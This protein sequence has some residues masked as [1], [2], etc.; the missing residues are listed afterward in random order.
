MRVKSLDT[1]IK[2]LKLGESPNLLY[3][4]EIQNGTKKLPLRDKNVLNLIKP[5]ATFLLNS[6][7][8]ILFFDKPKSENDR[9]R[10]HREVW[11]FQTPI[12]FIVE[13]G[14]I[15]IYN[16]LSLKKDKTRLKKI[17]NT[18][19]KEFTLN[20]ILSGQIW[21]RLQKQFEDKRIDQYLL[22]N[23][24]SALSLIT[25]PSNS[26]GLNREDANNLLGRL[27]FIRYL[28]DRNV[29]LGYPEISIQ[30]QK[31]DFLG[32]LLHKERLYGLFKYLTDKFN[33]NLFPVSKN[34]LEITNSL[35][36]GALYRLFKGDD[37]GKNQISLFDVYDFKIIPV[38]LISNIYERFIGKIGQ[39]VNKSFYTPPF[40][41]DYV[42]SNTVERHLESHN[43]CKVLDPS[44][45]SGIFL[46]ETLR[47]VIEKNIANKTES[48]SDEELRLIAKSTVFGVDK[49]PNAINIAIFSI[50]ITILDYKEPKEI[51]NFKLPELF[52]SNFLVADFFD[53]AVDEK[54]G[55]EAFNFLLGNPPWGNVKEGKHLE[56]CLNREIPQHRN[57][58]ARSFVA[59]VHDF[60]NE[61]AKSALVIT[62]KI[63]YNTAREAKNFRQSYFLQKYILDEVFELSPVRHQIFSNAIGPASIVFFRK[64]RIGEPKTLVKHSSLKPNIF[65]KLFKVIVLEKIDVKEIGQSTFIKNDWVW[66]ASLYG[67]T[68]DFHLINR[69]K[70]FDTTINDVIKKESLL[71]GVGMQ[72]GGG[73]RNSAKHLIGKKFLNTKSK[74]KGYLIQFFVNLDNAQTW[75]LEVV[76]RPRNPKLFVPPYVLIKKGLS[77]QFQVISAYSN[78]EMVFTDAVTAIKGEN[79]N[80]SLLRCLVGLFNSELFAYYIFMIGSSTGTEREQSHNEDEKFSFPFIFSQELADKVKSIEAIH[81]AYSKGVVSIDGLIEP[82]IKDLNSTVLNLYQVTDREKKLLEY[83]KNVSIPLFR[84]SQRVLR[85]VNRTDLSEYANVFLKHFGSRFDDNRN[86]FVIDLYPNLD[87]FYCAAH[88]R[89]I[90]RDKSGR[91]KIEFNTE[92]K[93]FFRGLKE[94]SSIRVTEEL[95]LQKDIKGFESD[96]FYVIK[97]NGYKNWHP[98][99]AHLDIAEFMSA[100]IKADLRK[101]YE[102]I[103]I[104]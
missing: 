2:N 88:F 53:S 34:E 93:E 63:L 29:D 75:D 67:N 77:S 57:E 9:L 78:E 68:H 16:G 39:S 10:I 32:L 26:L 94:L 12:V 100:M 21:E 15:E 64:K 76:H 40:L 3:L 91:E 28:I 82:L 55:E 47:K 13:E 92:L 83:T 85:K 102:P 65:F 7:P 27:I 50:Y 70:S 4:P 43:F 71:T 18:N 58:I 23:L 97:S 98:S 45:G 25:D 62:S 41:V 95:F 74:D 96:S 44:C 79:A 101:P 8:F 66:K 20:N 14:Q 103:N 90:Q 69:L 60:L 22:E 17:L 33:G 49:D 35:H 81:R 42:L 46:V 56:Y 84:R 37:L 87:G 89:I 31:E 6:R 59:R 11:N 19:S 1:L 104:S 72:I 38:E 36:L 54:F 73:D 52:D 5:Y 99:I 80:E 30:N 51:S 86:E 48:L 61:N 24:S